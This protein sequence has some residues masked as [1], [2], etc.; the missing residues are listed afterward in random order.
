MHP[1]NSL[2]AIV[3][4][5]L[6]IQYHYIIHLWFGIKLTRLFYFGSLTLAT[7][8]LNLVYFFLSI[9]KFEFYL[10]E[11]LLGAFYSIIPSSIPGYI[12][13]QFLVGGFIGR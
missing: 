5:R 9:L 4:G 10:H 8:V 1:M 13:Q 6:D 11:Q 2:T 7:R 12:L 3:L